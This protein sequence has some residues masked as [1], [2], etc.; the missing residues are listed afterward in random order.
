M[1]T[2]RKIANAVGGKTARACDSCVRKRARWYCAADDAFLCQGCDSMVHSA[3]QLA[4]RHER[5]RLGTASSKPFPETKTLETDH[6]P[7]WQCGFT[8][9]ARTPRHPKR[10]Q[11]DK[12]RSR[13]ASPLVPE[14]GNDHEY[15]F[16][17]TEAQL[18]YRVPVFDP[19]TAEFCNTSNESENMMTDY[20]DDNFFPDKESHEVCE[21][22]NNLP[23]L[24]PSDME[25]A[26]FA[27]DVETL[28]GTGFSE[29]S[30]GI[31]GLGF[32][33]CKEESEFGDCYQ[34]NKVKVEDEEVQAAII[35]CQFDP[36]LD[37][38][39]ETLDWN[40]GYESPV[41]GEDE[42]EEMKAVAAP[43]T[44]QMINEE[45]KEIY[46]QKKLL[47]RLNYDGVIVA[48]DNHGCPWTSG[49]RPEINPNDC[50]L[51]F[52]T[53]SSLE[54]QHTFG[55]AVEGVMGGSDG[56]REARVSRYREKRRTRLF[57]KK[58]R[59]EVRKLNAEKR[60]R[61][62]GRFVKRISFA[63]E[64]TYHS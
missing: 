18:L 17:E 45:G 12:Q 36:E 37:M 61:I 9:K 43:E 32:I 53:T 35:A 21:D 3:N 6:A 25:L 48:W 30:C 14:M 2:D 28:L 1:D 20:G 49:I 58:I 8:R 63:G 15:M 42:L 5:V 27:V 57:S 33:E 24:L 47:L 44:V 23:V 31:E 64:P 51:D 55:G 38:S 50:W 59:Y 13:S 46:Q 29:E 41:T 56:G 40:F 52:M 39:K 16:E 10:L 7:A 34:Q 11:K 26:D 22:L 54:A 62:K 4:G 19:F 60:P